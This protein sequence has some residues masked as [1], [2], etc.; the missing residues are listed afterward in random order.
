MSCIAKTQVPRHTLLKS[1]FVDIHRPD[2]RFQSG[3]R[4]SQ[5]RCCCPRKRT[6]WAR[7]RGLH[8]HYHSKIGRL[9]LHGGRKRIPQ[10]IAVELA[11]HHADDEL[12]DRELEV[13]QQV[14]SGNANKIIADKLEISE[15]TLTAHMRKI[16]CKL[17]A[18]DRTHPVERREARHYRD[19]IARKK[20]AAKHLC[21]GKPNPST[22][23]RRNNLAVSPV[24][25]DCVCSR[26]ALRLPLDRQHPNNSRCNMCPERK[27]DTHTARTRTYAGRLHP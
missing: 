25:T 13:L 22:P 4:N 9:E 2:L 6:V 27:P 21:P 3:R 18:N 1:L 12:T 24:R 5:F 14:A 17:H 23:S 19:L 16:L 7:V 10:E 26:T 20:T 11:E 15:E 8:R